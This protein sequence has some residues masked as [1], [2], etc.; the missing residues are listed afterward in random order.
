MSNP[1]IY[2]LLVGVDRYDNP[3]QAPNLRGCVADTQ[4]MYN[5]LTTRLQVPADRIL[6]LTSTME[7]S[8]PAD[9]RATRENI[10]RGWQQH[11]TKAGEGDHVFFHYSGHGA[12]AK[13]IDPVNEPDGLDETIVPADSRT[14]GV[15]DILD[16]EL[17]ALIAG[18]EANGAKVTAFMD[19]CHSG[20]GT[21]KVIDTDENAP[22]TRM[23]AGDDRERPMSTVVTAP[24]GTR[25]VSGPKGPS[26]I[27]PVSEHVLL[28]GCRD[29]ELSHEYRSPESGQWQG[30]TTYFLM[31]KLTGYQPGLTWGEVHDYVQSNVHAVYARQSPQL[32]G[33]GEIQ[34]FGGVGERM[35]SYAKVSQI[36]PNDANFVQLAAGAAVGLSKG[37]RV[38]IYGVG[39]DMS[40]SPLVRATV[41]DVQVDHSWA[42]LDGPA[43]VALGSRAVVTSLGEGSTVYKVATD[44]TDVQAVAG[45]D[46]ALFVTV[47]A[48]ADTAD[49]RVQVINGSYSIQ[50]G[51]GTQLVHAMPPATVEGA[52]VVVNNLE[53]L[54]KFSNART[55]HNPAA[56]SALAGKVKLDIVTG[57]YTRQG[58]RNTRSIRNAGNEATLMSGSPVQ[59][60]VTNN[61]TETLYM[62]IL[63]L[64]S[65][66]GVEI[67]WPSRGVNEAVPPGTTVP[68]API[69]LT[70]SDEKLAKGVEIFKVIATKQRTEFNSL[71]MPALNKPGSGGTRAIVALGGDSADD[72]WT[73]A[74]V[75][76]TVVAATQ[77]IALP[78]GTDEVDAGTTLDITVKKPKGFFGKLLAGSFGGG[79]RAAGDI[80][81][82]AAPP[83][84]MT[85]LNADRYFVPVGMG[86]GGTRAADSAPA[87][88]K[89]EA[90]P[91]Q[92]QAIT[93]ADPMT[94]Q[95][96]VENDPNIAGLLPIAYDGEFYYIAGE[97]TAAT[98]TRSVASDK[99]S[100]AVSID[101]LPVPDADDV[102]TRDL[103]R[104]VS[105]FLYKIMHNDLPP[106][107]GVRKADL[108][109][110]GQAAY[111]AVHPDDVR[112]AK[113]VA[114]MV[115]GFTSD[116]EWLVWHAWPW[117]KKHGYD[118]CLTYDY[119][120]F[121]TGFK[122]NGRML[123]EQLTALGF[124]PNDGV[125]LDIF[126]HSMGTQVSRAMIELWGGEDF[127]DRVFMGGALN[128]GSALAKAGKLLPWL[129]TVMLNGGAIAVPPVMVAAWALKKISDLAVGVQDMDP[130]SEFFQEING[131]EKTIK[132]PYFVQIGTNTGMASQSVNWTR[133]FTKAGMSKG[134]DMGLDAVLGDNDI[135]VGVN[136]AKAVL[137]GKY[138]NA[139]VAVTSG[140]HFH[141]FVDSESKALLDGWVA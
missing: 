74:Q 119:E 72:D 93:P 133:L 42:K 11:L 86:A 64:R 66:F 92:F 31:K 7:R 62:A 14:P 8:E 78:E 34:V 85:G 137:S 38:A 28:A 136:S 33:P 26:G 69:G 17:A 125:K 22:R 127:V 115:H 2:A 45:M 116:T 63:Y 27:L 87:V 70:L 82:G 19:C 134:L 83:P 21:R 104:T 58:L 110:R 98:G 101:F 94:L 3:Q 67:Y 103:K 54:A 108:D 61:H 46:S 44:D 113:R 112:G 126:C 35:A 30:A 13:T 122:E 39:G 68:L 81:D 76:V 9:R 52:G 106:G 29:E 40:G 139:T 120:T 53:H 41:D 135:A 77:D 123:H 100:M 99:Q 114:L 109:V 36:D 47:P 79:S 24:S 130:D 131:S 55:L 20:S 140:N 56:F 10:L 50:D 97:P 1:S 124:G 5:F 49:F 15:F 118:L 71:V 117:A 141:Y 128:A 80:T 96:N 16:K 12:Q 23:A 60:S 37:S 43:T 57:D 18:V 121:N 107:M 84:G 95:V 65:D 138:P 88:L 132:V 6:W 129:S 90:E 51:A 75:E 91:E 25:S 59:I 105:L 102:E 32:E 89:F 4:A 48:S 73:T 111:A